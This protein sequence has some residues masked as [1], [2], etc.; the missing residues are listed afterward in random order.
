M[1][2]VVLPGCCDVHT[3]G[4]RRRIDV[5]F[6]DGSGLVVH[7]E[8]GLPAWKR[9]R[10]KGALCVMERLESSRTWVEEGELVFAA[11]VAAV[12]DL[13]ARCSGFT[14]EEGALCLGTASKEDGHENVSGMQN[15][16]LR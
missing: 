8:R 14:S 5:A 11:P 12:G 10:V 9:R 3:F 4:M 13:L 16:S 7:A 15:C 2:V 6:V 1:P